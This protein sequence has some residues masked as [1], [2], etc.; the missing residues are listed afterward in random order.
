MYERIIRKLE[1]GCESSF[2]KINRVITLLFVKLNELS[3][4]CYWFFILDE[5]FNDMLCTSFFRANKVIFLLSKKTL[6]RFTV[7]KS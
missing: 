6:E 4:I 7:Q 5:T 3:I 2:I 1:Q